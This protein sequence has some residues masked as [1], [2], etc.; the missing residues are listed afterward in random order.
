MNYR[1]LFYILGRIL[2]TE[3]ILMILPLIC[4]VIY[5]ENLLPFIIPILILAAIAAVLSFKK[6]KETTISS[7]EGFMCV[8]LAW[9]LLSVFG[10][11]PFVISGDIPDYVD[12]FFE[13]VSGFTTTGASILTDVESLGRGVMFWRSFTHWVGG[14][15][16]LVFVLAIMPKSD[17]KGTKYMHLMRAEVPGPTV[18]KLVPKI[19]ETAR[20][21]YGIYIVLTVVVIAL[22]LAGGMTLFDATT[23]AFGTAGTGG[24]G[25]KNDSL[26]SYSP[27]CQ[28]VIGIFM[29]VFGVN[30]NLYYFL[31]IGQFS[32]AFKNEELWCYLGIVAVSTTIITVNIFS[33]YGTLSESFRH[34]FLQVTSIISTSGFSTVDF[35][36]WPVLSKVVLVLLMFSGASAGST[37]GGIKVGR[38][39]LLFKNAR[40]EVHYI[41]HPRSVRSVKIDG[42][43]VD[44]DTIRGTTSYIIMYIGIFV[45]SLLLLTIFDG[46]DMVSGFTAVATAFNNVGPALEKFGP[47]S[48]FSSL[49]QISKLLLSFDMLAGRLEIFPI[50]ILL[51]P[52]SWKK[53]S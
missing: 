1:M 3:A 47:A 18:G 15:G 24:F 20:V 17:I 43:A 31:L 34:S 14:M 37:A 52:S 11:L 27:Y 26:A 45:T 30:F 48:N 13:T 5:K 22:L 28:Y 25:I 6:P 19:S 44:S 4:A 38:I 40:R 7:R 9:I 41:L 12:A 49:S 39:L 33:T 50:L 29:V 16:V 8:A 51:S 42:G 32:K 2:G 53:S 10:A 46:V 35:N 36:T 23:H 21:M